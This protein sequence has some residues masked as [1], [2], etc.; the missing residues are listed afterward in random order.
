[1][2][3]RISDT[4]SHA[5]QFSA[6]TQS[7]FTL[8]VYEA[9][10]RYRDHF[11]AL[12]RPVARPHLHVWI[13]AFGGRWIDAGYGRGTL[14]ILY[15]DMMHNTAYLTEMWERCQSAQRNAVS[16]FEQIGMLLDATI[17]EVRKPE[18]PNE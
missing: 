4:R 16:M 11:A 5:E 18:N 10:Q 12:N 8:G 3:L 15:P 6:E 14:V 7:A 13:E 17:D 1:M 9:L 2:E